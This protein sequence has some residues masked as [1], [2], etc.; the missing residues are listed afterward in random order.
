MIADPNINYVLT[1]TE[2][3]RTYIS[4]NCINETYWKDWADM[5]LDAINLTAWDGSGIAGPLGAWLP[6]LIPD[7][8]MDGTIH[9][10]ELIEL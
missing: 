1:G 5:P 6:Y 8:E 10:M 9:V 2:P 7:I 3:T 4:L